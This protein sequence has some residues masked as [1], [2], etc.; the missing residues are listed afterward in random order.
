LEPIWEHEKK[1]SAIRA[2]RRDM[3]KLETEY[4]DMETFMKKKEKYC[5]AKIKAILFDRI[6]TKIEHRRT[7]A[8]TISAFFRPK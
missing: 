5:S 4:P 1:Q 2:Y 8:Q 3:D 7:G 6:L